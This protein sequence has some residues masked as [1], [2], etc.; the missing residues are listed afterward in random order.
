MNKISSLYPYSRTPRA[1]HTQYTCTYM[2]QYI[3]PQTY[4][5]ISKRTG[6]GTATSTIECK[7]T[8]PLAQ[9]KHSGALTLQGRTTWSQQSLGQGGPQTQRQTHLSGPLWLESGFSGMQRYMCQRVGMHTVKTVGSHS[10]C[11]WSRLL[12]PHCRILGYR[13]AVYD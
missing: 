4:I 9:S 2:M 10:V 12:S 5:S 6:T 13:D 3:C 11:G 1:E 7:H 8:H